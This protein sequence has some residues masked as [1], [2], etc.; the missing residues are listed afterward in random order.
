[1]LLLGVVAA[2]EY[3]VMLVLRRFAPS[4]MPHDA[5]ID[6]LVVAL[7]MFPAILVLVVRPLRRQ[8]AMRRET[9]R[10]LRKTI[11]ALDKAAAEV[12]H[13]RGLL[14]ICASCKR[15]RNASGSW[16]QIER[17]IAA[18]SEASFTHGICPNCC[19]ELYPELGSG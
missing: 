9:E 17:Y 7:L 6:A 12:R 13:L 2:G 15:I 19:H 16:D 14:P 3:G 5:L 11:T 10:A 4:S 18:N 8:I 1:M